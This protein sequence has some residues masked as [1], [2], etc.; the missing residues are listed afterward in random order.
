[1]AEHKQVSISYHSLNSDKPEQRTIEPVGIFHENNHWYL[2][3]FCHLRNDYRQFRT[4]RLHSIKNTDLVS[5]RAI[6]NFFKLNLWPVPEKR[7]FN[8]K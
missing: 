7:W 1:M 2:L 8:S 6:Q 3:A 4:D 5:L